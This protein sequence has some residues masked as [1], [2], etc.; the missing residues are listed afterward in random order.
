MF[1]SC[2]IGYRFGAV[3]QGAGSDPFRITREGFG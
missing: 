2:I 3:I 1:F